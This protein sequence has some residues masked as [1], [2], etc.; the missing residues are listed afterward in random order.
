MENLGL[1]LQILIFVL[2]G[3]MVVGTF[4]FMITESLSL[5]D[6]LYFSIVTIATV[7]YGDISPATDAG[8]ILSIFLIV[9]GVGT[10]MGVVANGTEILMHKKDMKARMEK[11]NMVEGV[12]F[13]E[14]GT[15]LLSYFT[16]SDSEVD[17]I[18][19]DILVS[20]GWSLE[21]FNTARER[22]KKHTY[23]VDISKINLEELGKELN[24]K[25]NI[26]IRLLEN[27][28]LLE[29]ESFT[30]LIKALIHLKDELDHRQDFNVLPKSDLDHLT[31]DIK[32]VYVL[33]S[34]H[35]IDH[36]EYLK[37]HYPYLFSLTARINPFNRDRSPIVEQ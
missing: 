25:G 17:K 33:L 7:G 16:E 1:R 20:S 2:I 15:N 10:F 9:I 22:I 23:N 6:S 8:K 30:A 21:D 3:I 18:S 29:H 19:A 12:F 4:G 11:L 26:I 32:R 5:S 35:W 34:N 31:G 28:S 13:S 14:I 36:A 24:E 27:P 37:G